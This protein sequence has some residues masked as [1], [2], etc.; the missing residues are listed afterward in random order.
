MIVFLVLS[1]GSV[2]HQRTLEDGM[3]STL[4]PAEESS[5]ASANDSVMRHSVQCVVPC[6]T[7]SAELSEL[8]SSFLAIAMD[9][10]QTGND[11]QVKRDHPWPQGDPEMRRKSPFCRKLQLKV[12]GLSALAKNM[13]ALIHHT[14]P[15]GRAHPEE[16]CNIFQAF[17]QGKGTHVTDEVFW[18]ADGTSF[19]AEY[20]SY[21]VRHN[22]RVVGSVVT[23]FDITQ[24]K[25]SE[26]ALRRSESRYRSIIERAPYGVF[27]VDQ[28]GR[29]TMANSDFAAILG[30]QAPDEVLGLNTGA[31]VYFNSTEQQRARDL[32]IRRSRGWL[33]DQVEA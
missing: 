19:P 28:S 32:C 1:A 22:S 4:N 20:W 12:G 3:Y 21:P 11:N 7:T 27:R 15:D 5:Q 2:E 31:D 24:R 14:G 29:I 16:E 8:F 10:W 30:H 26:E 23:F 25:K 33:R 9:Y 17:Q 18:R 13:H 6:S